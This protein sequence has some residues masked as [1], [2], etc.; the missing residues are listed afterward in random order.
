ME[1]KMNTTVIITGAA[2]A[3][4]KAAVQ[5]F[6]AQGATVLAVDLNDTLLRAAYG[7][8]PQVR[9]LAVDLVDSAATSA[10]LAAALPTDTRDL[11]L[12]NLA[13][14]FEMGAPVH[15]TSDQQWRRMMDLNVATM[16]NASRALVPAMLAAGGG[17]IVN[18]AAASATSG[19]P[20]MGAYC[21]SKDAVARLTE[22]MAAELRHQG[23]NVNAVAPTI[24]DT[25]ANRSAMPSADPANWVALADLAA[26]IEFLASPRARAVHGAVLPV[27]GL[28]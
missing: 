12:C 6:M 23:I 26:V 14:A 3:L 28:S 5:V 13:G 1:N 22:S 19:K 20:A 15:D 7:A 8:H 24:L 2:G 4:G 21:A 27:A 16:I 9:L 18:V 11:V 25:P 17:K 10:A